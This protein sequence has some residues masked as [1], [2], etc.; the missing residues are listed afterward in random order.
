MP[1][2][3]GEEFAKR[4]LQRQAKLGEGW[5]TDSV[6]AECCVKGAPQGA[7]FICSHP[8]RWLHGTKARSDFVTATLAW[9][10]MGGMDY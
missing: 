3:D 7:L 4:I 2:F 10:G 6:P 1:L 5:T 9:R 8:C